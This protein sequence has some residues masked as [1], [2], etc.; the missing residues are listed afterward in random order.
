MSLTAPRQFWHGK[1]GLKNENHRS[2]TRSRVKSNSGGFPFFIFAH[3][4]DE[5]RTQI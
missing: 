5:K 4:Q 2:Q 3:P 1:I